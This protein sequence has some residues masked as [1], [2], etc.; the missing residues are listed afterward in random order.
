[1]NG[2]VTRDSSVTVRTIAELWDGVYSRPLRKRII[3]LRAGA[4]YPRNTNVHSHKSSHVLINNTS[5]IDSTPFTTFQT[6]GGIKENFS[7]TTGRCRY[8]EPTTINTPTTEP[9]SQSQLQ[10]TAAKLT[11]YWQ[12]LRHDLSQEFICDLSY[13]KSMAERAS[14]CIAVRGGFITY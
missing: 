5:G 1:M 14:A 12:R 9:T 2:I 10:T 11:A 4:G 13:I 7:V 6:S 8:N 3:N